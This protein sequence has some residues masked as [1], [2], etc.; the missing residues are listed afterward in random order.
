ME[1]KNT[2]P[3]SKFQEQFWV[4]NMMAPES[5]A[6]NIPLVFKADNSFDQDIF[7]ESV[8]KVIERHE[9]LRT[10]FEII[11][12]QLSQVVYSFSDKYVHLNEVE[13]P[14]NSSEDNMPIEILEEVN[15]PFSMDKPPLLRLTAFKRNNSIFIVIVFHHIVIDLRSKGIFSDELS[16]IYNSIKSGQELEL[17]P[18]KQQYKDF[19]SWANNW[20]QEDKAQKLIAQ[21][22]KELLY[23]THILNLPTELERPKYSKL[24]G[25]RKYFEISP[26]ISE[27]II[28]ISKENS[29][30]PFTFLLSSYT[31][32]LH[33]I[34][35]Q[36]EI[37][38]GVPL[39]NRVQEEFKNT[40]GAFVNSTPISIEIDD[41]STIK[42][43]VGQ[44]RKKL[45][46]AHRKQE[47]P[48]TSIV[49]SFDIKRSPA[50][51][52]M[53][54]TGFTFEPP[55]ELAIGDQQLK[56][57][58]INRSGSQ[59]DMYLTLWEDDN[60][61][62]GFWEYSTDLYSEESIQSYIDIFENL[63]NKLT[64]SF[65]EPINSIVL[66]SKSDT[67]QKKV[68]NQT[69]CVIPQ[70][71]IIELFEEQ[72][73][74]RPE[75][76]AL[77]CGPSSITYLELHNKISQLSSF[78]LQNGYGKGQVIG[79]CMERSI[80]MVTC[81]LAI[82]KAGATYLPLDPDFPDDR[83]NYM[84][85]DSAAT[86][87]LTQSE[88]KSKFNNIKIPTKLVDK[89]IDELA[90]SNEIPSTVSIAMDSFAYILYT[91]GST[92]KP[93]G[94]KIHHE[95]LTNF[96]LSMAKTPGF[97]DSD[98]LL[99]V[100]TI[101]FDISVLELFLPLI[102]GGQVILAESEDMLD[103]AKLINLIN[104]YNVSY[105]QATP[106]RWSLLIQNGWQGKKN[107]KALVGGEPLPP[108]LIDD[109]LPRVSELWNMY[110]PTETTVWSTC[111]QIT[112]SSLPILVGKPIDNTE[113]II[114]SDEGTE[115][116]LGSIGEVLIGGKGVAKG[117]YN[118]EELTKEKFITDKN[119]ALFY[120]TGDRGR[121]RSDLE[122]ELYGRI[123]NQIKIRGYRVELSEIENYISKIDGVE[124][125]VVKL[126]SFSDLDKR[127]IAF[128]HTNNSFNSNKESILSFLRK[129][130]PEYMV[131][132]S[133]YVETQFPRTPNGKIDRKKLQV[134]EN[135]LRI[136]DAT[137]SLQQEDG[138]NEIEKNI[139]TIWQK[140]LN[141]DSIRPT[142]NFFDIG[143]TSLTLAGV[144]SDINKLLGKN[145]DMVEF[146]SH[147]TIKSISSLIL[148]QTSRSLKK[149]EKKP[150]GS[151]LKALANKRK[152]KN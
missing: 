114:V 150:S 4:L 79:V 38:V 123:D 110:G 147:T 105:F 84:L 9:I 144:V 28:T 121:I 71:T 58:P 125:S 82:M 11:D 7:L 23:P 50:Y 90:D 24:E 37:V 136:D 85:E 128:L 98:V 12:G 40:F 151:K 35:G 118:R 43:L 26:L 6:Y 73:E 42:E 41:R 88:L 99:S 55:M 33:K 53:Y 86:L 109:L 113:I 132:S 126:H 149:T 63:C 20:L 80:D 116:A 95:A 92:G 52:V 60:T 14:T 139:A 111:K 81:L 18:V 134:S 44:V 1:S 54:Q 16:K 70:K 143:G 120:K 64:Y 102:K 3:V 36:Q 117:Y 22:K 142:D 135:E 69:D 145:I 56:S 140:H 19:S 93:K 25:K 32:F 34:T 76:Q 65:G 30:T 131:P 46:L 72:V 74:I 130:L 101:S 89:K 15:K 29:I 67:L 2:F 39:S 104:E 59:L 49:E 87:L 106:G 83:L 78:L 68:F 115:L 112:N 31:I 127:L 13:L 75:K 137:I 107:F 17:E 94:V 48:F 77:I 21:W 138:M 51:N 62:K 146:F 61:F 96:L 152:K 45:L 8:N 124:E 66:S 148:A 133:Y 91:S 97:N 129:N 141:L 5:A 10:G 103:G 119:G 108:P 100:T 27:Q 57:I 47:V 122:L